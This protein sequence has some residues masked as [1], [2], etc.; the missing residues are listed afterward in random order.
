MTNAL[1]YTDSGIARKIE[2]VDGKI[3]AMAPA[4]APHCDAIG[5][6]FALF[7]QHLKN[8]TCKVYMDI[9]VHLSEKDRFVPDITV[10]CQKNIMRDGSVYG[11][12][13]LV[14]EVLSRSTAARDRNQKKAAYEKH[15]VKEYWLVN[16]ADKSIEVFH[17]IDGEFQ[18]AGFYAVFDKWDM[19]DMTAEE[20]ADIKTEFKTSIFDD[21]IIPIAEI[22]GDTES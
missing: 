14:V 13:D 5:N 9:K 4:L 3:Y 18:P 10:V 22:F 1:K 2:M 6:I 16:P 8:K 21:L 7:H 11:A 12:P 19:E 20:L 15:G 17:L